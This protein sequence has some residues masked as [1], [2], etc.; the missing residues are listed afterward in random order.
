VFQAT[1]H[2]GYHARGNY[3]KMF[4]KVEG[5]LWIDKSDFGW[6]KVEAQVTQPFSMGLFVARV[7]RGSHIT[8]PT[9]CVGKPESAWF[10]HQSSRQNWSQTRGRTT[11]I[12]VDYSAYVERS[13]Q[14]S[15]TKPISFF[16]PSPLNQ[17]CYERGH[18]SALSPTGGDTNGRRH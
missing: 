3:D 8:I 2:A 10:E 14:A 6:I 1:P 12:R 13:K 7:Q 18:K 9:A 11:N 5:K 16:S 17:I 4:S 15:S